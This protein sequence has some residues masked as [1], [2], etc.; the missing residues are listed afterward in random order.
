MVKQLK[1]IIA[2]LG[3]AALTS[4]AFGQSNQYQEIPDSV[5]LKHDKVIEYVQEGD[6]TSLFKN[7]CFTN[8]L[9]E[10]ALVEANIA[11]KPTFLAVD[12][13]SLGNVNLSGQSQFE[14]KF[15]QQQDVKLYEMLMEQCPDMNRDAA[16][17]IAFEGAGKNKKIDESQK[18]A[19][20]L[21]NELTQQR[22]YFGKMTFSSGAVVGI[23][24]V[25]SE[26]GEKAYKPHTSGYASVSAPLWTIKDKDLKRHIILGQAAVNF[27]SPKVLSEEQLQSSEY[28]QWTQVAPNMHATQKVEKYNQTSTQDLFSTGLSYNF[29]IPV[30]DKV[31]KDG[32]WIQAKD[33]LN[34]AVSTGLNVSTQG[35]NITTTRTDYMF[36]QPDASSVLLS[37]GES[38]D[39][40]SLETGSNMVL[41]G[42]YFNV[43]IPVADNVGL[44]LGANH[45][46]FGPSEPTIQMGI[47]Y[48]PNT[49]KKVDK[50]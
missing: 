33:G 36:S 31:F 38:A 39:P 4:S 29:I 20:S 27:F 17:N 25:L 26:N 7:E 2:G 34:C 32:E 5:E 8:F 50:Q 24:N 49:Y 35:E 41:D 6:T 21:N 12:Y 19:D 22:D 11:D 28:T 16:K 47:T 18:V 43:Q 37:K 42:A 30:K 48:T 15:P 1:S 9:E 13:D 23:D 14:W 10:N 40:V 3:L 46:F 45:L 44:S